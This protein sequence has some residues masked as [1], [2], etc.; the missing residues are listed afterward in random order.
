MVA[1]SFGFFSL[2]SGGPVSGVLSHLVS[3]FTLLLRA[4]FDFNTKQH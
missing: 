1:L 4:C 2:P 3:F